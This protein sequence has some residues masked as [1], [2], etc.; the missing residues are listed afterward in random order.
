MKMFSL[1]LKGLKGDSC[2]IFNSNPYTVTY[3]W[4]T[5]RSRQILM[6]RR[7][8]SDIWPKQR[9]IKGDHDENV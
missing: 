3:H 1:F 7:E 8:I 4:K 9:P 5:L 6:F 2:N